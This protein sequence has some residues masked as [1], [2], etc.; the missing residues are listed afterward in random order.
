MECSNNDPMP[1]V[2]N[3]ANSPVDGC[4]FTVRAL[5]TACFKRATGL[6]SFRSRSLQSVVNIVHALFGLGGALNGWGI[7]LQCALLC[8]FTTVGEL[9]TVNADL[10]VN[11][12][13]QGGLVPS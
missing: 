6:R 13:G 7:R 10:E 11:L 4:S 1:N 9:A 12:C 3:S 5:F 2:T 8:S